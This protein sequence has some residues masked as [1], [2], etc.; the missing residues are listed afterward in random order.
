MSL[1]RSLSIGTSSLQAHQS[2]FDVISNNLA[3]A[4]TVGYK[5]NRANFAEQF[6]QIYT[7]GKA[8]EANTGYSNGGTN[9]LQFAA[10][11]LFHVSCY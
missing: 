6:N 10:F 4:S 8:P 5:A 2:K 7:R 1:S 3:N 11:G 9:P